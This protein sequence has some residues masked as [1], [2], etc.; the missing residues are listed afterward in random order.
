MSDEASRSS[1]WLHYKRARAALDEASVH[2]R[3]AEQRS[4]SPHRMS[5]VRE[6]GAV[7]R[8]L[9]DAEHAVDEALRALLA[10]APSEPTEWWPGGW[11]NWIPLGE[12][13]T[14]HRPLSADGE[15]TKALW[16]TEHGA[17]LRR[18]PVV[19]LPD[20]RWAGAPPPRWTPVDPP[21]WEP[22]PDGL[23][24]R[25]VDSAFWS[26]QRSRVHEMGGP[27]GTDMVVWIATAAAS[28]M[29]GNAAY[30][31]AKI[32]VR[33]LRT[34]K[35]ESDEETSTPTSPPIGERG[36]RHTAQPGL[37]IDLPRVAPPVLGDD[38]V[39]W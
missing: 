15:T 37:H 19:R 17:D 6:R 9:D 18:H 12:H 39:E 21:L 16:R 29:V 5:F 4:S 13:V 8:A 27:S 2:L 38:T 22:I 11:V 25:P 34:P 26:A 23:R 35:V 30:D 14:A 24:R 7:L 28:G 36:T 33:R 10:L 1:Q 31:A 32:A 20:R 3:R